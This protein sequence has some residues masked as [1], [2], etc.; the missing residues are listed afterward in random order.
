MPVNT[1]SI[2]TISEV[3]AHSGIAASAL[4][5]YER[6]GLI[7]KADRLGGKRVWGE[8]ILGRL[9]LIGLAKSAGFTVAEIQTMLSGFSRRYPAGKRW[10]TLA[11]RK[12]HELDARAIEIE[13]MKRVLETVTRCDC[14]TLEDCSR[15]LLT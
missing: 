13:Q 3:A 4:R 9:A 12:L 1:G 15:A 7:P 14:P 10:R 2:F 6:Q 11:E 5:Y 8:A